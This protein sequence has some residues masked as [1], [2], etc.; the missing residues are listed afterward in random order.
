MVTHL[1]SV[2]Q[3]SKFRFHSAIRKYGVDSWDLFIVESSD[4][5]EYIR[6]LEENLILEHKTTLTQFGYNAK[7]VVVVG[8]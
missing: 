7:P 1:S 5:I 2:K 3:G 4:D 6:K 8:G